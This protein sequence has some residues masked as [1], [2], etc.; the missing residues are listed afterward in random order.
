MSYIVLYNVLILTGLTLALAS[1]HKPGILDVGFLSLAI[2]CFPLMLGVSFY[3]GSRT[4]VLLLP[5][6]YIVMIIPISLLI[7]LFSM[8]LVCSRGLSLEGRSIADTQNSL[9][10]YV[11][12]FILSAVLLIDLIKEGMPF[13][14]GYI[15]K[16]ETSPTSLF[17][18]SFPAAFC[19]AWA[20]YLRKK[21]IIFYV[22]GLTTLIAL[23]FHS[24]SPFVFALIT[25]SIISVQQSC[26]SAR[27]IKLLCGISSAIALFLVIGFK[28][29]KGRLLSGKL[30]LLDS[31]LSPIFWEKMLKGME[32]NGTVLILNTTISENIQ[33]APAHLLAQASK[34]IPFSESLLGI[35]AEKF[36][37]IVVN[38]HLNFDKFG[39]ANNIWAEFYSTSSAIGV[40]TFSAI[41]IS[42]LML[43]QFLMNRAQLP[44]ACAAAALTPQWAFLITRVSLGS[45]LSYLSNGVLFVACL[46]GGLYILVAIV[47][48]LRDSGFI[49]YT[50][51]VACDPQ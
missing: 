27:V 37:A 26:Y 18:F 14:T 4:P 29:I 35:N 8:R 41:W 22:F 40:M 28:M 21:L 30:D 45:N 42:S 5:E 3:P 6:T 10:L 19:M 2:Y 48:Y 51:G 12:L 32:P 34:I 24:R 16:T 43:L 15:K 11:A 13:F 1:K 49:N 25:F 20:T 44:I 7:L 36:G 33:I 31:P 38:Q 9:P 39:W 46:S 17:L 47:E 50:R 23:A